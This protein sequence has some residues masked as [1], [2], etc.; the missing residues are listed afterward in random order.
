[1]GQALKSGGS[2]VKVIVVPVE[3]TRALVTGV[4]RAPQIPRIT[5]SIVPLVLFPN[6]R[7][8]A[9]VRV[10][11]TEKEKLRK[12]IIRDGSLEGHRAGFTLVEKVMKRYF[13]FQ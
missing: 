10:F 3:F 11:Y 5:L 13:S 2:I 8:N 12:G 7:N 1:M 6:I 4:T 9:R